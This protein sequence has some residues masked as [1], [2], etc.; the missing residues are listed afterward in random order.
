MI[1]TFP[2]LSKL[3]ELHNEAR[4][5]SWFGKIPDLQIDDKLMS[6]ASEWSQKMA[7]DNNLS[8]SNIRNIMKLGFSSVAENIAHG[9][10]DEKSVMKTWLWSPGHRR[11][12][13]NK[14]MTHIGCGFSYSERN[15]I[16]WCV[17][18]GKKKNQTVS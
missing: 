3:V 7:E 6:Y 9:Q 5:K 14:S 15:T 18:F 12:I 1:Y 2:N 13:M 8:H 17:C 16:Y 4:Q 11:N 10:K